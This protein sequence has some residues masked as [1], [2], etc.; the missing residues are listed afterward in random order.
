MYR[1]GDRG[2]WNASGCITYLGRVDRQIKLRGFRLELGDLETGIA[3]VFPAAIRTV[4]VVE[5]DYLVA[6]MQPRTVDV[7]KAKEKVL[8]VLPPQAVPKYFVT[9]DEFPVT[10][11]GKLDYKKMQTDFEPEFVGIQLIG[12]QYFPALRI[13]AHTRFSHTR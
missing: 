10:K 2:F 9:L 13:L 8:Q 11:A 12:V 4:V 6:M 5:S 1:T 7:G 3:R